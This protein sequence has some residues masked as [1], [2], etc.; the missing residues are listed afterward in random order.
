MKTGFSS[1]LVM[2]CSAAVL[3]LGLSGCGAQSGAYSVYSD[4]REETFPAAQVQEAGD[5][6]DFVQAQGEG[7]SEAPAPSPE[8]ACVSYLGPAGTYTEEAAQFFFRRRH[9]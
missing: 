1:K 6:G 4:A 7:M 9:S 5:A 8:N 3:V 2:L